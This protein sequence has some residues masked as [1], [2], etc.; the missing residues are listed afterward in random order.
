MVCFLFAIFAHH[1]KWSEKASCTLNL[2]TQQGGI[3]N[4]PRCVDRHSTLCWQIPHASFIENPRQ[5]VCKNE[6]KAPILQGAGINS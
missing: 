5:K 4:A 2:P 6:R 1:E 3:A